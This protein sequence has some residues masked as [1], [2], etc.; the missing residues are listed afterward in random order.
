[1]K[2][3][4]IKVERTGFPVKIAGHEFFFDCSLEHIKEYEETYDKVV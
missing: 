3:L 1:M 4:E 2:A